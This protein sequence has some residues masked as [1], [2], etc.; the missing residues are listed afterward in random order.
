[1]KTC[2][3]FRDAVSVDIV[4]RVNGRYRVTLTDMIEHL[5]RRDEGSEER[6]GHSLNEGKLHGFY[7]SIESQSGELGGASGEQRAFEFQM[8][9]AQKK[10]GAA[11]MRYALLDS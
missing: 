6:E 11:L 8:P 9:R 10:E 5:L 3:D 7:P 4:A 2:D 1:M